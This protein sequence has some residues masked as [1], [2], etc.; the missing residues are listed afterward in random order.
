[1]SFHAILQRGRVLKTLDIHTKGF[2]GTTGNE[3]LQH[4]ARPLFHAKVVVV[5]FV[6]SQ[7]GPYIFLL[8]MQGSLWPMISANEV[9]SWWWL[10]LV[11]TYNRLFL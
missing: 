9:H 1:M 5:K 8:G 3:F 6:K 4:R 10:R 7:L 11:S 2:G